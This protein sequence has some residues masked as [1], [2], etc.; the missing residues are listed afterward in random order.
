MM[1]GRTRRR[2][3]S[4]LGGVGEVGKFF[5]RRPHVSSGDLG[6]PGIRHKYLAGFSCPR[7]AAGPESITYLVGDIEILFQDK[8]DPVRG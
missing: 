1:D 8:I 3:I 2:Q 6:E 7:P 4:R 5:H